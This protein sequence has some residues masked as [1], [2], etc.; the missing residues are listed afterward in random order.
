ME[1]SIKLCQLCNIP[2]KIIDGKVLY[3]DFTTKNYYKLFN[4]IYIIPDPEYGDVKAGLAFLILF[5][6]AITNFY[7]SKEFVETLYN[8]LTSD[9]LD[10]D[11][12]EAIKQTIRS[13]DW[14]Y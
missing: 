14:E 2:P 10:K 6:N 12:V 3:V 1:E 8:M 11:T 13:V 7:S 4:I 5:N 9:G